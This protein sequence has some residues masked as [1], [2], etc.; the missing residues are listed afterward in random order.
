MLNGGNNEKDDSTNK[1]SG[2]VTLT[3]GQ[4]NTIDIS[5]SEMDNGNKGI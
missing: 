1:R 2:S 3:S 4:C 5:L